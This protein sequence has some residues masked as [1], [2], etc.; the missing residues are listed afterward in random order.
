[1]R[2][3]LIIQTQGIAHRLQFTPMVFL[4]TILP[5]FQKLKQ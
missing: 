3:V 4:G 2:N 5:I 1:M